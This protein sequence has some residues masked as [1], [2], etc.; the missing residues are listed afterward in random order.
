[1]TINELYKRK[2]EKIDNDM[3]C[4]FGHYYNHIPEIEEF[5][6]YA[7]FDPDKIEHPRVEIHYYKD[8]CF[9][10]RRV[11]VLAAVKFDNEF[12]MVIQNAGREGD[13]HSARFVTDKTRYTTMVAYLRSLLPDNEEED[14]T[15]ETPI[16][17]N[18]PSLTHFY[19]NDLDGIFEHH[20]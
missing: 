13:D 9:D 6:C 3:N 8:F 16:D 15:T 1:M 2:P 20:R 4:L 5:N 17:E 11:W 7:Y 12:V 18:I 19:G 10:G 14:S